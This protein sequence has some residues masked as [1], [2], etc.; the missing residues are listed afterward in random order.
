MRNAGGG[1]L[2]GTALFVA[3]LLAAPPDASALEG[4]ALARVADPLAQAVV[5]IQA[6]GPARG[7][8]VRVRECT[9]V[10]IA[11][12]LVLTAGHCL[13]DVSGPERVGV[14]FFRGSSPVP[15]VVAVKALTR[16]PSYKPGWEN[17]EGEAEARQREIAADLALLR[18]AVPAPADRKP[19][20]LAADPAKAEGA[21]S[22]MVAAGL[23]GGGPKARSG[24]LKTASLDTIRFT[25]EMPKIAFASASPARACVGDSGG[26]VLTPDG[27]VWGVVSAVL[28]PSGGCGGRIVVA[29]IQAAALA[30]MI[31]R[32]GGS[33]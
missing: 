15:T 13:E 1:T 16:H 7:G 21:R 10:L 12:D 9:G 24:T 11:R 14:F 6:I 27:R 32:V 33:R 5:S 17:Q 22:R 28:R 2:A 19:I 31:A 4:G 23:S 29:P 20:A 25:A 3:A 30:T 8:K 18:L 26:P